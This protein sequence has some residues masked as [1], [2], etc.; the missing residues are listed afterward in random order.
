[1]A[2]DKSEQARISIRNARRDANDAVKKAVEFHSL[3]ED[4]KFEAEAEVQKVTDRQTSNV[5]QLLQQ[6]ESEIMTV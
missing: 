1:M 4:S 6:K 3:P 5:D 2:K